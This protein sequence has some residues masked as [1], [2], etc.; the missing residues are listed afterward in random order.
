MQMVSHTEYRFAENGQI[1]A[2]LV[3]YQ[4]APVSVLNCSATIL[5]PDKTVF[6]DNELM[7]SSV[8]ISGDH[9]Y[10]FT[11]PE[12][13]EG[14]YEYQ[15]TCY[16]LQG[17]QTKSQSVTNSFHL[18]SAF[19]QVLG[20]LSGIT[21][22][23]SV[24]SSELQVVNT[25]VNNIYDA[26]LVVNSTTQNT[27]TYLTGTLASNVDQ[28]LGELG[29]INATVNRIEVQTTAINTTTAQI[30]DNQQNAVVMSVFSG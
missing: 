1:I 25:T 11:T 8:N 4:G 15:A 26:M 28:I 27:Y 14:V 24:V 20:N 12:G 18:S 16:Y 30:L 17:M 21:S 22:G 19:N 5:Y 7:S 3:D 13:P 10:G 29:I 6:A 23:F 2:R 9:F